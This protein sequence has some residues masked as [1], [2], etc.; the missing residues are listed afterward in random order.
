MHVSAGRNTGDA[1]VS[2]Q[3]NADAADALAALNGEFLGA[4]YI[5]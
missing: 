3:N 5:E 4:R 1:F 2:L